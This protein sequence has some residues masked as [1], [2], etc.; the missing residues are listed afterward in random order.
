MNMQRPTIKE[1]IRELHH[2]LQELHGFL[3]LIQAD[4]ES[5]GYFEGCIKIARKSLDDITDNIGQ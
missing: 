2:R 1:S 3:H 5:L 4:K